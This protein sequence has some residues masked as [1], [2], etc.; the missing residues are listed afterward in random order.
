MLNGSGKTRGGKDNILDHF[1]NSW[2]CSGPNI[3]TNNDIKE[4]R[5]IK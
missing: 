1:G 4:K 5:I 2:P 3:G